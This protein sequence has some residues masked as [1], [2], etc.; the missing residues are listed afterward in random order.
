MLFIG[1]QRRV[2]DRIIFFGTT[3]QNSKDSF[4]D[5][6]IVVYKHGPKS[7]FFK[8]ATL[9]QIVRKVYE[10]MFRIP[11][12]VLR[13]YS[14]KPLLISRGLSV[15]IPRNPTQK[16]NL[17]VGQGIKERMPD[18]GRVIEVLRDQHNR[19]IGAQGSAIVS[20][21]RRIKTLNDLRDPPG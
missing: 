11:S 12:L 13:H 15:N 10:F 3:I 16:I 18:F 2:V 7:H 21:R 20:L 14:W 8:D 19:R 1:G 4:I 17:L 5:E 9:V 6:R